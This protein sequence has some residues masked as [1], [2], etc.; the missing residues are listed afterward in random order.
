[1]ENTDL[2]LVLSQRSVTEGRTDFT[3]SFTIQDQNSDDEEQL[4]KFKF[5]NEVL[6][7]AVRITTI[8]E[9]GT[10]PE[11]SNRENFK[12]KVSSKIIRVRGGVRL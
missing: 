4:P 9:I 5:I 10:K 11:P 12:L 6:Q 3:K 8:N 7:N 2:C 1:M